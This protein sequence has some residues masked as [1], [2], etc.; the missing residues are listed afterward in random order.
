[1]RRKRPEVR[2]GDFRKTDSGTLYTVVGVDNRHCYIT[3]NQKRET[4]MR[5]L[6]EI[7]RTWALVMRSAA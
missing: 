3:R 7:V 5:I 6:T 4:P 1:M 2:Q